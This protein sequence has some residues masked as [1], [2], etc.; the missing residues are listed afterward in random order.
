MGEA[1]ILLRTRGDRES[2]WDC[3]VRCAALEAH[4]RQV[5]PMA[6]VTVFAEGDHRTQDWLYARVRDLVPLRPGTTVHEEMGL[7]STRGRADLAIL[8]LPTEPEDALHQA[9]K[10]DAD[11]VVVPSQLPEP[12]P[13]GSP[14]VGQSSDAGY[15]PL[16]R[17]IFPEYS[18]VAATPGELHGVEPAEVERDSVDVVEEGAYRRVVTEV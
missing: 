16:L 3:V 8:D 7:R 1:N 5:W 10:A 17:E 11:R 9:W 4:L 2:G 6:R 15:E 14:A 18:S 12:G 13:T